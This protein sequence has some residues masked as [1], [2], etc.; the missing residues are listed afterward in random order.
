ML[1]VGIESQPYSYYLT[2]TKDSTILIKPFKDFGHMQFNYEYV[3]KIEKAID[4]IKI[5]LFFQH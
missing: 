3:F 2:L 5:R 4:G 1:S